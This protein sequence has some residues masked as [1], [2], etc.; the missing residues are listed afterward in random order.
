MTRIPGGF[1]VESGTYS[2][3]KAAGFP[4]K[5][6]RTSRTSRTEHGKTVVQNTATATAIPA[7]GAKR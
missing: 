5:T 4:T 3:R 7:N 6:S 2:G 1:R